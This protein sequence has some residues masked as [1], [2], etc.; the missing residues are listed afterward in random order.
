MRGFRG[1]KV[2][3]SGG[4]NHLGRMVA[5]R[6]AG[7]G[8]AVRIICGDNSCRLLISADSGC[9]VITQEQAE[10]PERY[11]EIPDII[12]FLNDPEI[13]S[14]SVI[15]GSFPD[16]H[17]KGLLNLLKLAG[18][19][20][21]Y[22]VYTSSVA[23]YG[24]Q[25]YLPIDED[26]PLDPAL[27]YGAVK[28]AGEHFCKSCSME[29]GFFYTILRLGDL[30]GPGMLFGDP[31]AFIECALKKKSINIKGLGGQVRSY[32][33]FE[34]AV[35]ATISLLSN[36]P[37]NQIVNLAGSEFVS[38]WHLANTIKQ[39]FCKSC[40][41]KTTNNI[42]LDE[43]E[44]CVDSSKASE[45]FDFRAKVDLSTGLIKTHKWLSK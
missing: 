16:S 22:F 40:E 10:A 4:E 42:L 29:S 15:E 8:A 35:E 39:N 43:M 9:S 3:V 1:K 7:M 27:L 45:L 23:V 11:S 21:S 14:N 44:C 13:L 17:L 25:K 20:S 31:A 2:L 5:L 6:L 12:L 26:H 38:I 28:L 30:Y 41:I 37:S 34:D 32:L 24:K 19:H 33:Y 18:R 36:K